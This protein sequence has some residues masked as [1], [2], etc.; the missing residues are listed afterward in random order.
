[1]AKDDS[2]GQKSLK[3]YGVRHAEGAYNLNSGKLE[4]V[5]LE[6]TALPSKGEKVHDGTWYS[7]LYHV[8]LGTARIES[9]PEI[10][11]PSSLANILSRSDQAVIELEPIDRVKP[12]HKRYVS[13]YEKIVEDFSEA[14]SEDLRHLVEDEKEIEDFGKG[15]SK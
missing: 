2:R 6:I 4:E 5:L 8:D 3:K 14:E 13:S 1:M 11:D 7:V 9:L 15:D 12:W 10:Q